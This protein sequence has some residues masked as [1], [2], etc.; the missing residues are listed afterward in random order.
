MSD[1]MVRLLVGAVLLVHGIAHVG[2]IGALLWV[3]SGHPTGAGSWTAART[4]AAPA[5]SPDGAARLAMTIDGV[6]LVGFVLTALAFWGIVLPTDV[7]RPLGV[8]SAVISASGIVVFLGTWPRFNTV[9][10]LI[11]NAAV[12]AAALVDWPPGSVLAV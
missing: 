2:A 3:R 1:E 4:W 10:A 6:A 11:V 8:V 12:I 7:W 9:A 5:M